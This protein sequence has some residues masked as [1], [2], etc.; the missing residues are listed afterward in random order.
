MNNMTESFLNFDDALSTLETL[1][2]SSFLTDAWIPS[3]N[4]TI[5]LKELSAK[6]QMILIENFFDAI[7]NKITFSKTLFD[8]IS[9]NCLEDSSVI[10]S[11]TIADKASLAFSIRSQLSD[12]LKVEFQE[13]PKIE[14][15]IEINTILENFKNFSHPKTEI[16]RESEGSV[17]IEVQIELPKIKQENDFD[18]F[19]FKKIK[20]EDE[21]ENFKNIIG[22]SFLGELAKHIKEIKINDNLFNYNDLSVDNKIKVVEKLPIFITKKIIEKI[23]VWKSELEKLCTVKYENLDKTI[24]ID[25][26]LFLIN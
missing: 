1:T 15:E 8:I 20:I 17:T 6:Q 18:L 9:E 3:L 12:K 14:H 25:A 23:N 2:S 4:K 21:F 16:I 22:N 10:D 11:L 13:V 19:V 5:Q 26:L 24:K 7:E